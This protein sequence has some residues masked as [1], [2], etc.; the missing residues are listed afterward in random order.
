MAGPS[1]AT[2]ISG[3]PP[4]L[5]GLRR[6]CQSQRRRLGSA[7]SKAEMDY[8]DKMRD[9]VIP[10][11]K[12]QLTRML[13]SLVVEPLLARITVPALIITSDKSALQSV[14]TVLKYQTQIPN[15]RLLVLTSDAYHVAVT[16]AD[17]CV[18]NT[19][20]FYGHPAGG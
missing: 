9:D 11:T 13:A 6:Y 20:K 10:E 16:N 7:A 12:H 1:R 5:F 17:E 8:F 4:G 15:S 2:Q 14:E 19:L 3:S 18:T